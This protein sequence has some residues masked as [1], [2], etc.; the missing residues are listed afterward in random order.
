MGR[1][2]TVTSPLS[3]ETLTTVWA[4]HRHGSPSPNR[5]HSWAPQSQ[6]PTKSQEHGAAPRVS[7]SPKPRQE[8]T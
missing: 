1:M 3:E 4:A 5:G 8:S 6:G 2:D 7:T